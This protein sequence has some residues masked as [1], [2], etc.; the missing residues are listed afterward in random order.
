MPITVCYF[1]EVTKLDDRIT[2]LELFE[3]AGNKDNSSIEKLQNEI[4]DLKSKLKLSEDEHYRHRISQ[5]V[6]NKRLDVLI[7]GISE[8]EANESRNDTLAKF[9]H[10]L[11]EALLIDTQM[12]VI[13]I[14][15]L[16]QKII[17]KRGRNT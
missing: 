15:R 9:Q 17:H 13:D 4:L 7:H 6:Y 11:K 14:H 1:E 5:E 12:K 8:N 16:P 10:F 3:N 2:I